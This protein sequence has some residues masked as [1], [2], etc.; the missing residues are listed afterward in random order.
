MLFRKVKHNAS[1][2]EIKLYTVNTMDLKNICYLLSW[3][4]QKDGLKLQSIHFL[5]TTKVA[6]LLV[7]DCTIFPIKSSQ[8]CTLQDIN[9]FLFCSIC[10][11]FVWLFLLL[12]A[13]LSHPGF[14][15]VKT[16]VKRSL[17]QKLKLSANGH[18]LHAQTMFPNSFLKAQLDYTIIKI[19]L[20]NKMS[21]LA[22]AQHCCF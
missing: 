4:S 1:T 9:Y 22:I 12:M 16:S 13:V 7:N 2:T 11:S 19:A 20:C 14:S 5:E 3:L 15:S 8:T 17:V 21:C 18:S 10:A 6:L